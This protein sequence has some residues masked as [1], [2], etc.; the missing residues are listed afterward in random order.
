M[1]KTMIVDDEEP[2]RERL[3]A[4]LG[5]HPEVTI[6]DEA[7]DGISAIEKIE[8]RQPDLVFLDI[9]MP[10][11]DGLEVVRSITTKPLPR[12][13]FCTAYDQY[14]I[15]AFELNAV[16]YLLKPVTRTRLA[17]SVKRV[18]QAPPRA[19][20]FHKRL[21]SAVALLKDSS[22][23]PKF[24]RRFLGRHAK[25]IYVLG[26]ADILYFKVDRNLVFIVS[27]SGEYWTNYTLAEVEH[28]A[29]PSVFLRTHRQYL[30]NLDRIK[31]IAPLI[32]GA[33]MLTMSNGSQ[34]EVSRRQSKRLLEV[35]K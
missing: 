20:D 35:L 34:V 31:E 21:E 17:E 2:A 33:Y 32:G 29:D 8:E 22:P 13:I 7:E 23:S 5:E 30:V 14:A 19:E 16:D 11:C 27:D 18:T 6:I 4:L 26:E 25:R 1:I 10:G 28:A 24:M 9:Q 15:Q 12:V 3:R